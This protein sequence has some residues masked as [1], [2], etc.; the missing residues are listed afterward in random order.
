MVTPKKHKKFQ[1]IKYVSNENDVNKGL[2]GINEG[3]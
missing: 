3:R 1:K 2:A